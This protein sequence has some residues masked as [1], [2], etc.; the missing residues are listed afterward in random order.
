MNESQDIKFTDIAQNF[1]GKTLL[2]KTQ[3]DKVIWAL[4]L[5]LG[6]MSL[7]VVYSATSSLAY[8]MYK[9]NTEVYLF[10]QIAFITIGFVI[11]YFAHRV[12]YTLYSRVAKILFLLSI[13]LLLYT[14]FFGVTMNEGSRWIRLPIIN[15]TMQ[16]SDLAKLA[17]FMFLARMLSR[18]QAKIKDF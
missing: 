6:L 16:T 1:K 4:V 13:P 2:Q 18:K 7:L 15:L 5:L 12:N 8:K 14:L 11:I 9:G 3:G 17:L 10:K